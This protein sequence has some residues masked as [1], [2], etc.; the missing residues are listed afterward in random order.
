[1]FQLL[2]S[3]FSRPLLRQMHLLPYVFPL[4]M[5]HLPFYLDIQGKIGEPIIPRESACLA[6]K[7]V[8]EKSSTAIFIFRC[9]SNAN[10]FAL[11]YF[12]YVFPCYLLHLLNAN[13]KTFQF[14]ICLFL[15]LLS[16]GG[17]LCSI[18]KEGFINHS[19]F[20]YSE[21]LCCYNKTSKVLCKNFK[22]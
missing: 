3:Y 11:L 7:H 1:M 8:G 16:W 6:G 17:N 19:I 10:T 21:M 15:L 12:C 13:H 18:L 20:S 9:V 5:I 22:R 4:P 2:F 14:T